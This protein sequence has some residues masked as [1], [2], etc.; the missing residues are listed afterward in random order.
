VPFASRAV[1]GRGV[2]DAIGITLWGRRFVPTAGPQSF[3]LTATDSLTFSESAVRA[4]QAFTRT[5]SESLTFSEAAARAAQAFTRTTAES[6]TFS[7]GGRAGVAGVH[8]DRGG[9]PELQRER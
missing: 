7:G 2:R 3:N 8:A 1:A 6:L 4:P 9:Q 5:A